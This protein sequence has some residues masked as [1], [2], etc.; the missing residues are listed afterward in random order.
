VGPIVLAF[1]VTNLFNFLIW[2]AVAGIAFF[3]WQKGRPLAWLVILVGAAV[4]ALFAFLHM[5]SAFTT[6]SG[7][8]AAMWFNLI[9]NALI[10]YGIYLVAKPAIS[11]RLAALKNQVAPPQPPAK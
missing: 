7:Y 8:E 4:H 2:G 3:A 6:I 5:V 10:G 1:Q 11:D 9:A